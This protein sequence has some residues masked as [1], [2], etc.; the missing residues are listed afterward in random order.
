MLLLNY[1]HPA[2][3]VSHILL[4][5]GSIHI[6]PSVSKAKHFL[7]NS[8]A[9]VPCCWRQN[10]VGTFAHDIYPLFY[11]PR[12]VRTIFPAFNISPDL[13]KFCASHPFFLQSLSQSN[14]AE[15][16]THLWTPVTIF[17]KESW[18]QTRGLVPSSARDV[19]LAFHGF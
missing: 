9:S 7:L 8:I 16:T 10:L 4:I 18:D 15:L 11:S 12:S 3:M 5:T 17:L 13:F 2:N 19:N 1:P 14:L 6:P